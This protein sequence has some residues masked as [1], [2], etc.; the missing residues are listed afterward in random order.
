MSEFETR[1]TRASA[2]E[3]S[4]STRSESKVDT[5]CDSLLGTVKSTF[6][7]F[8]EA[9]SSEGG[10]LHH[11]SE[12]VNSLASLQGMPSQLLNTGI[13]QIPLLD[14]MPGM[15]AATIGVP[16]LGTPH[17]HSHPP[18]SG[19][20]LPSVGAT[21]G[22]GCLSVLIGGIPA[23]RV[24]D[25]GIAPTCGGITPFFDIQT[26]SSN[27]FIGGMRAARMGIDMTR[28]CNPMGHVGQSGGEAASAAEKSEEVASEAA[29]VTGRAKT[30]GRAGKA[31]SVGNAA[32]GPASGVATAA[33]DASQGEIA[34]AAMMA[35][36]TA[37]DLAFMALS[38][39][40][41]KDPGIEPSMGTLLAGDP[42]VLIGGF[43]LPD[44][45]MMWHGAKHGIGKKV[46]PKR[47]KW[48][49][50]LACEMFGEPVS[51][52][53]G[54]VEN[55]FTDFETDAAVPFKWGRH[56]CSGWHDR[57][58]VLGYGFRHTWQ[59]E[60]RL[61]RTRAVYIDPHGTEYTFV[62]RADTV[63]GGSCRGYEIE[64]LDSLRFVI[65]HEV[66]GDLEFERESATARS[67]RC[68]GHVREEVRCYLHY[69]AQ[70]GLNKIVQAGA[71]GDIRRIVTFVYE[72]CGRI[73]EVALT[74]VNGHLN[75][76]ARYG[77][78]AKGCLVSYRNALDAVSTCEYDMQCR[79]VRLTDP[80][81][82]AFF[83]CYD[84]YG[85][86]ISSGGQDGL[87]HVR[88]RYTPGR[89]FV[90]ESD[91]GKWIVLYNEVG[92][93]T[94]VIDPYDGVTE[95]TLGADG[96]IVSEVDSGERVT[97]WIY[98][99]NGRNSHRVDQWGNC[100]PPKDEA[101]VV[102][103]RIP[104]AIPDTH[105]GQQ[106]GEIASSDLAPKVLTPP[107]VE[108]LADVFLPL[109]SSWSG[110][111]IKQRDAAGR[112]IEHTDEWGCTERFKYDANAN[113]IERC[114]GDGYTYR[115]NIASWNLRVA[116]TDPLN[117]TVHV[118]H[119]SSQRIDAIVDANGNESSYTYDHKGRIIG[120]RR[121]GVVRET[122][123]YDT[124]NLLVEKRDGA[125][126]LLLS[127][128]AGSNG[129]YR[130]R[131]L[132]SGEIH[133]YDY[134]ARGNTVKASTDDYDVT[135]AYDH[136]DRRTMD[137]RDGLGVDHVYSGR[138]LASTTYFGRFTVYY[139]IVGQ[140][141]MRI[142]TPEGGCHQLQRSQDGR[143]LIEAANGTAILSGFDHAKRCVG[144][145]VWNQKHGEPIRCTRHEY[146]ATGELRRITSDAGESTEYEYDAAHRLVG[147]KRNGWTVRK[148]KYDSAGNLIST[149][150]AAWMRYSE[151]NRLASSSLGTFSHN[152]RN[153]VSEFIRADGV[154]T[155]YRYNSKDL[156]VE[157]GWSDRR[158]T[159]I[160]EYDGLSR[161]IYQ[162]YSGNR[163]DY[164]WDGDRLAAEL[165]CDGR[166]RLYVYANEASLVPF[167]FVDYPSADA[168]AS[169]GQAYLVCCNQ[170]GLPQWIEDREGATVWAAADVDP[171]G[172]VRVAEGNLVDYNLRFP[173]HYFDKVTGL[174]YNRFRSYSPELCRYLQSDPVGQSGGI[175]LYAYVANP[176]VRVDVLG[177]HDARDDRAPKPDDETESPRTSKLLLPSELTDIRNPVDLAAAASHNAFHLVQE[178][179]N[180]GKRSITLPDGRDGT[181][182]K[183]GKSTLGP[184]LT[185]V[186]FKPTLEVFY[187]QNQHETISAD[188]FPVSSHDAL[189]ELLDRN[190]LIRKYCT[191]PGGKPCASH[192]R[193]YGVPGKHG[194]VR[195]L[196][197]ALSTKIQEGEN[198]DF[199]DFAM[200]NTRMRDSNPGGNGVIPAGT[201]MPRCLHCG[202]ATVGVD[203][204]SDSPEV[205]AA[206]ISRLKYLQHLQR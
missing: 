125:G 205:I 138:S 150:A 43:P 95:Y 170:V 141:A 171:Y 120:V 163:T 204:I 140:S 110:G 168:P 79:I 147:E 153:H 156:L 42:T 69:T 36:Q 17:A 122:Y 89:T 2:P 115:Y 30:L 167:L 11:V 72:P 15:P 46:R 45:Q 106:W 48:A 62:R 5:A 113:V 51:A 59:H 33:D 151:G 25:I 28:H 173:G 96:R 185:V 112:V 154:R 86:C 71:N 76:I 194:D 27:T 188:M 108:A 174:H 100:W 162:A 149:P 186:V 119:T 102:P 195:V 77:Y 182:F 7:P 181:T 145:I 18:S 9:F 187:G 124:A 199:S 44:S 192:T 6:D 164:Y 3:E 136:A 160:A 144:Q 20:P 175:N 57:D 31:W 126:N 135:L 129:R 161:R 177:L 176:L 87:W 183:T 40:M 197:D 117:N 196:G 83:Y 104:R 88:F 37:A 146:S 60:L 101:P 105:L 166:L 179:V 32:I 13:A 203:V 201:P 84:A 191:T 90:T 10:T 155:T 178:A 130:R 24:L 118:H 78:D 47:P 52:V 200:Y 91:G 55:D 93:I 23:A 66:K 131:R 98:D 65:R 116:E 74:D 21:I 8:K 67:A 134:D 132:A 172:T 73:I 189:Q 198:P 143:V 29:Q 107:S 180:E 22:S 53:T 85:R 82:Y 123:T 68:T 81:G 103:D 34:A 109:P 133:A 70:G 12:A 4:H 61:F 202:P 58:G 1:L 111:A 38:N 97:R 63:Y 80:N 142:R 206:H 56:Y 157:V 75:R 165:M 158:E 35:A 50:K 190:D 16:H 94:R 114:D 193:K 54:E 169:D 41:G 137:K 26:G 128:D 19:F 121:H 39:L 159:W 49:Q 92:T 148:F 152:G 64:Q 14:K 139:E 127:F 184:C 99:A